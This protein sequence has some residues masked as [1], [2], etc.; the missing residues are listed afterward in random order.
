M[1]NRSPRA[2]RNLLWTYRGKVRRNS[3]PTEI[4]MGLAKK[5]KSDL[6]KCLEYLRLIK[7]D[8]QFQTKYLL[9]RNQMKK[10]ASWIRVQQY[11]L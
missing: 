2:K 4:V 8:V 5:K 1:I 9:I 10:F 3:L 7:Y 6:K 11:F